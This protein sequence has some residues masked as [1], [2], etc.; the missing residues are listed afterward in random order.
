MITHVV[1]TEATVTDG[2]VTET[3]HTA[4]EQAG[5]L[6]S[7]H[8]VDWGYVNAKL[9]ATSVS[10]H[11][12]ELTGPIRHDITWQGKAD[13]PASRGGP[14]GPPRDGLRD[15]NRDLVA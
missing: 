13:E 12:V 10:S 5:L 15:P 1:T 14:A 4:L 2:E 11:G 3:I 9:L 6:A 8:F 7:E